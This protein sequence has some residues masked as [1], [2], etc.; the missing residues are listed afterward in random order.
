MLHAVEQH[1]QVFFLGTAPGENQQVRLFIDAQLSA[2]V[3]IARVRVESVQ[4]HAQGL[5]EYILYAQADEFV[6]HDLARRQYPVEVAVQL[7]DVGFDII[8]H[9]VA[10]AVAD[11]QR[12]VR[13]VET[14]HGY[15]ELATG[16][17]R[18]PGREVGVA[19]FNQ[20]GLQVLQDI[21]PGRQAK[22]ESIGRISMDVEPKIWTKSL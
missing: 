7:A 19:D 3:G 1:R 12:Q 9:P 14:D 15:I 17:Q 21:A 20:V 4:V 18:R 11:Q 13:M 5:D 16:I 10:H 8:G 22:G 6:S 2:Q